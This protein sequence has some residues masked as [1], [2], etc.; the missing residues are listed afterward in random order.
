[1]QGQV[2]SK[3]VK[4]G[5]EVNPQVVKP[6]ERMSSFMRSIQRREGVYT[7][8]NRPSNLIP[9]GATNVAG[10]SADQLQEQPKRGKTLKSNGTSEEVVKKSQS[11]NEM[12]QSAA[13][14]ADT[15]SV[16]EKK[17]ADAEKTGANAEK[18][19]ADAEKVDADADGAKGVE[20]FKKKASEFQSKADK[21]QSEYNKLQETFKD[22][23]AID[24]KEY[25]ELL[26]AK[27]KVDLFVK[28][29]ISFITNY[30]PDLASRLSLAGDPVK[31]VESEVAEF[32]DKLAEQFRQRYG[33]DWKYNPLEAEDPETPS[34]RF[35]LAL[36]DK[37]DEVRSKYRQYVE[38]QSERLRKS[39]EQKLADIAKLKSEFGF[40]DEDIQRADK[41]L[42][43][44]GISYYNLVRLALLDDII[45]KKLA[46]I[47]PTPQP[48]KDLS[49]SPSG[50]HPKP[51][52][53]KVEL[54]DDTKF[55]IARLGKR[56]LR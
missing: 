27:E 10:T 46:S 28:D 35:R 14:I 12:A 34:F 7:A 40:S 13:G 19:N 38:Q 6:E 4:Q 9:A 25:N 8:T 21:L 36:A 15:D 18:K 1:M 50:S 44:T 2:E 39:E 32:R 56:V 48:S 17:N 29:P 51:K 43:E 26:K 47:P 31:M 16:A 49:Q 53:S 54:S 55:I 37:I 23:K 11:S 33:E 42:S 24:E 20:Y 30:V 22:K 41:I 3:E 5:K 45:Q 52:S